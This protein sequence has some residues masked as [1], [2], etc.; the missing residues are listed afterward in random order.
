MPIG[1]RPCKQ[2]GV[3]VVL[4]IARDHHRKWFCTRSCAAKWAY[5]HSDL[6]IKLRFDSTG[7]KKPDMWKKHPHPMLGK[8]LSPIS[9]EK[10]SRTKKRNGPHDGNFKSGRDH[11]FWNGGRTIQQNGYVYAIS[12]CGKK[13][14]LEHRLIMGRHLDR[15]LLPDEVVHHIDGNRS[16]NALNNLIIM[17]KH[18]HLSMHMRERH[19][20]R[21][22]CHS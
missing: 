17:N 5:E 9:K 20:K 3:S 16:N 12:K 15:D 13:Y 1:S 7:I 10:M 4:R 8:H 21:R 2:C 6:R 22:Q 18:E 19:A 14:A 11:P